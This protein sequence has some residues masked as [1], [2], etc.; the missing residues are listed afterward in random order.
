MTRFRRWLVARLR[1]YRAVPI[2]AAIVVISLS[3]ALA[4]ALQRQEDRALERAV[5]LKARSLAEL[6]QSQLGEYR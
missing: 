4:G 5:A 1:M 3:T 2:A 6:I